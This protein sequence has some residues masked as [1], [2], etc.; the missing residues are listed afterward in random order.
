MTA[1]LTN[2]VHTEVSVRKDNGARVV[3]WGL[4]TAYYTGTYTDLLVDYK[5]PV[6]RTIIR[7]YFGC[8]TD[9]DNTRR[10]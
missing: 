9:N 6:D 5:W 4:F 10:G 2:W 3:Q 7:K 1:V 8:I